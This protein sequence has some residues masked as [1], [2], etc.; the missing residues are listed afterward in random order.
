VT[1]R[2]HPRRIQGLLLVFGLLPGIVWF[3]PKA[4]AAD[5][6]EE[7][8]ATSLEQLKGL[9][10][11]RLEGLFAGAEVGAFPVGFARGQVL[12]LTDARHARAKA[13]MAGAVW[14]G[15]RFE[16]DGSFVNQWLGFRA[17]HSNVEPGTSW[18]DGQPCG[19]MEYPPGTPLFANMR[20]E[21]REI[22]PGLWLGL[23]W[24][25]EPRPKLRGVFA[26][27]LEAEKPH[28]FRR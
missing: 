22:S 26:L 6:L 27:E 23:M 2:A 25:R 5:D 16:E 9:C 24:E 11:H 13:K 12:L 18:L 21:I 14:K 7:G 3:S 19:V 15:K 20:D 10:I 1:R 8:P 4:P 17:L 28:R